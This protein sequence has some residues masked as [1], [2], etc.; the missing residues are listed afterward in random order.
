MSS[1]RRRRR[2]TAAWVVVA[3]LVGGAVGAYL[4]LTLATANLANLGSWLR[5]FAKSP[6]AAAT[7]AV[8]AAGVALTGI[9]LNRRAASES[10]SL[11]ETTSAADSWWVMFEWASERAVPSRSGDNALPESVTVATLA[12][13]ADTATAE[14]Q[15]AACAGMI[16]MLAARVEPR[17]PAESAQS[18]NSETK[19][20]SAEVANESAL[21]ALDSYVQANRGTKA[22]S[23]VAEAVVY[24][25]SVTKT[26]IALSWAH[27]NLR[28]FRNPPDAG[29]ADAIV[30]IGDQRVA[31]IIKR[32]S[33]AS[34]FANWFRH[35]GARSPGALPG[36]VV[37]PH[38]FSQRLG[39]ES[40]ESIA[41]VKWNDPNDDPALLQALYNAVN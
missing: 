7:A 9:I 14:V 18:F 33:S 41:V 36:V 16:D 5:D 31:V 32:L 26:L 40:A 38:P 4:A 11:Q 3:G 12:R 2:Q 20:A 19:A 1:E 22:A 10:L 27:D 35:L 39:D 23:S 29:P 15:Q 21:A 8:I 30:E 28:V 17:V 25:N 34:A 24:E 6:G 13:L 37:T